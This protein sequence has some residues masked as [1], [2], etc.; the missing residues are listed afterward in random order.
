MATYR[1]IDQVKLSC[2]NELFAIYFPSC[3]QIDL[4][5]GMGTRRAG[6]HLSGCRLPIVITE[7]HRLLH[8]LD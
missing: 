8:L 5:D 3:L 1:E 4:E 2:F 7:V 6:V